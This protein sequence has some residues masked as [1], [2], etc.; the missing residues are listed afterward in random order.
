MVGQ[1]WLQL[2]PRYD[3]LPEDSDYK[4]WYRFL[5]KEIVQ[6]K[7]KDFKNYYYLF[8]DC[9]DAINNTHSSRTNYV[10]IITTK[11]YVV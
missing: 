6:E 3:R 2:Q 7:R 4:L 1:Y 5:I 8:M 10:V 9:D 11:L